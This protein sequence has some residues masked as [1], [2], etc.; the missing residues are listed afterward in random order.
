[1]RADMYR[2]YLQ[3]VLERDNLQVPA[4]RVPGLRP[5]PMFKPRAAERAAVA[6]TGTGHEARTA[7]ILGFRV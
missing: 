4:T 1:M 5:P 3:P 2:Q 6:E 7:I